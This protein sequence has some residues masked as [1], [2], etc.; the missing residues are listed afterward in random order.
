MLKLT[1]D[2]INAELKNLEGWSIKGEKLH[3]EFQ[4]SDFNEAFAFMTKAAV[5][6]EKMNHHPEWFNVYNRIAIDLMTHDVGGITQN[7]V[8]LAKIMNSLV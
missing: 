1:Q 7:D 6:C 4:F 8:N 5:E 3:K 2:Q